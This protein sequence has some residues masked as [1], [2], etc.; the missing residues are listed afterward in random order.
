MKTTPTLAAPTTCDLLV[1]IVQTRITSGYLAQIE[2]GLLLA[3]RIIQLASTDEQLAVAK[4]ILEQA[5]ISRALF[6]MLTVD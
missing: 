5:E 2:Q 1:S 6:I 3:H 4:E